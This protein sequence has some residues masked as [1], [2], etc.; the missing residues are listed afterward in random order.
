MSQ[1]KSILGIR[2][3]ETGSMKVEEWS[4]IFKPTVPMG[5]PLSPDTLP[6]SPNTD[7]SQPG[8][9][10]VF[11]IVNLQGERHLS[12]CVRSAL[13]NRRKDKTIF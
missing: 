2:F 10:I 7:P 5:N 1:Q 6:I 3:G 13:P 4:T 8:T 12:Q 11:I 9:G